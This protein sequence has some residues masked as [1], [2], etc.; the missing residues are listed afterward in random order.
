MRQ[1]DNKVILYLVDSLTKIQFLVFHLF[2]FF[3]PEFLVHKFVSAFFLFL[4]IHFLL[5]LLSRFS[6]VRS[7]YFLCVTFL[8]MVLPLLRLFYFYLTFFFRLKSFLSVLSYSLRFAHFISP[9]FIPS[10]F[11]Y[12]SSY[13][14]H[15]FYSFKFFLPSISSFFLLFHPLYYPS[16]KGLSRYRRL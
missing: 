7:F 8:L 12:S 15:S 10:I 6:H 13:I 11:P 16:V 1:S 3:H 2:Y 9:P 5:Y 14:I 4:F